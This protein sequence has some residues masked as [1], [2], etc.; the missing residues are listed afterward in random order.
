MSDYERYLRTDEL[1][2]LQKPE[3]ER[4]HRDELLFQVVHQSSELWLRLVASETD[5]AA[6]RI[7][8]GELASAARLLQSAVLGLRL[9]AEQLEMLE[10]IAPRD[11][12]VLRGALGQGS[13]FDSPGFRSLQKN[14]A[15][16]RDAL[17]AHLRACGLA[18]PQLCAAPDA[19]DAEYR[20][21]ELLTEW[22]ER[23]TL[24]RVRHLKVVEHMIGTEAVGTQGTPIGLL[25]ELTTQRCFPELWEVRNELAR[26]PRGARG[27]RT[28][29]A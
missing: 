20:V 9:L 14:A 6:A 11:Y 25:R 12:H 17:L 21:A 5:A 15:E 18:L 24:W 8:A 19:H 29:G 10:Q 23:L 3:S 26:H 4:V 13:G 7:R 28:G 16:A 1:L 27:A 2:A 22:D